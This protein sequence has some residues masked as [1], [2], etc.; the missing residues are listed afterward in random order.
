MV[1]KG[2]D[3]KAIAKLKILN[4]DLFFEV[5]FVNNVSPFKW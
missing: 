3:I 4:L 2:M 1:K 5:T